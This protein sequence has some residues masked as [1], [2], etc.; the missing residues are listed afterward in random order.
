[1]KPHWFFKF[2]SNGYSRDGPWPDPTQAWFW[3]AVNKRPTCLWPRY[4]LTQPEEIFFWPRGKQ[5]KILGFLGEM[6]QTQNQRWLT[7][8]RLITND[9]H[10][11]IITKI[12][13][14]L[15]SKVSMSKAKPGFLMYKGS[16]SISGPRITPELLNL[17]QACS[18]LQDGFLATRKKSPLGQFK[19]SSPIKD[20]KLAQN[21]V[22]NSKKNLA[23]WLKHK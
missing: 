7:Q 1:M 4:F 5:L 12:E 14:D 8:P 3:P 23:I 21:D 16:R 6:F 11:K 17:I 13:K 15:G 9:Y 10:I 20:I 22:W 19:S 2:H 18:L